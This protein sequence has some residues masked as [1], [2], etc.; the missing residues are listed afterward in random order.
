M[1]GSS[2]N[3]RVF[4]R[5]DFLGIFFSI[6]AKRKKKKPTHIMLLFERLIITNGDEGR[7]ERER[8][9]EIM[10]AKGDGGKLSS[11]RWQVPMER[12]REREREGIRAP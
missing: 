10:D 6:R 11:S 7:G 8:E 9:R 2:N 5:G 12:V 4:Q 1:M 3:N